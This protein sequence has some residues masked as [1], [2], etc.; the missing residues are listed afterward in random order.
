[1]HVRLSA[2]AL[3]AATAALA[4][5]AAASAYVPKDATWSEQY[6][7]APNGDVLHA[8][9][10]RPKGL[11]DD[12]KTPV[13]ITVS[14]YTNHSGQE[15]PLDFD[16][17]ATGPSSRW[18]DFEDGADPFAHGYTYVIVDLP[19][20]G[21]SSGCTDW[22]GPNEQAAVK[23]AIEWAAT[24][25]WSTG[26]VG[27]YGKSYDGWTGLMALAQQ[28]KGL[29]AV[30]AQEPVYSGYKYEYMNG[31]RFST[32]AEEGALFDAINVT[33]GT[34]S[35]T[36]Q[37]Q[38]NSLPLMAHCLATNV[39]LQQQ[40]DESSGFW[41]VRNLIPA[42]KGV[43]T[44]TFL[45]QGF[46]ED[47]TK[48]DGAYDFFNNLAGPKRAWFGQW[49]HVRG[50][51][52]VGSGPAAKLAMGRKGWFDE[53][54]RFYDQYLKGEAPA[55]ADPPIAVQNGDGKWRTEAQWPP[56]DSH[57]LTTTLKT[58]TYADDNSN[59]GSGSGGGHGIWTISDPLPY[60][61]HFSG[62]PH[63]TVDVSETVPNANLVV[64]VYDI[65]SAGKALLISR[66]AQL[67]RSSG[68]QSFDLY[69]ED[70]PIP[71]GHRLGVLITGS[72][73][74]WWTHVPTQ[75]TVTV[76][77]AR[78][79]LPFLRTQRTNDLPGSISV[80]LASY[81]N[82]T[83]TVSQATMDAANAPFALPDPL[84]PSR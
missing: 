80:K 6:I 3:V 15:G 51:D 23:N 82:D 49:D 32:S 43:T 55:V 57:L 47:N 35:D 38:S 58:G 36:S 26:K 70:W 81:R 19:G 78:A 14:P 17:N 29:A 71:A 33:P 1:M 56:A 18:Q 53:I 21:G 27:T 46:L 44:P 20:F 63:V 59:S 77:S 50:N 31:V 25:P 79:S 73:S 45:T 11:P 74:E 16:P 24:Q 52:T 40:D 67:V 41:Q 30:V 64:D 10:L 66:G 22:G 76:N 62:V 65:D 28:P 2:L 75:Q 12:A 42:V 83:F 84:E 4:L 13:I 37:Y 60:D 9:V 54:L 61:V 34:S 8:D 5:P 68:L 48:P 69:G 39:A 7:N 72:N